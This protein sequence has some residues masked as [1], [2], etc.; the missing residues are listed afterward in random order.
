MGQSQAPAGV[1]PLLRAVPAHHF[2]AVTDGLRVGV[3]LEKGRK[4]NWGWIFSHGSIGTVGME[5]RG[6]LG[7]KSPPRSSSSMSALPRPP[8]TCPQVPH[9]RCCEI[10]AGVV[11]PPLLWA[12]VPE[13]H[14][15]F[16]ETFPLI[17]NLN[18]EAISSC[19]LGEKTIL[20]CPPCVPIKAQHSAGNKNPPALFGVTNS[21]Q[22][23]LSQL[24]SEGEAGT[25]QSHCPGSVTG[26]WGS[27]HTAVCPLPPVPAQS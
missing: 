9:P 8:L 27:F 5:L 10:P 21:A 18:P 1:S 19:H 25:P 14:N 16:M 7:W 15:S 26:L 12:A 2:Q 22:P 4:Q 20:T 24:Q 13:L 23:E 11:T 3:C 17:P 6:H